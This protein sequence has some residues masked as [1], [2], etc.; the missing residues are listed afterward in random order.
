MVMIF[1]SEIGKNGPAWMEWRETA[2]T[3]LASCTEERYCQANWEKL[4]NSGMHAQIRFVDPAA[5]ATVLDITDHVG[6]AFQLCHFLRSERKRQPPLNVSLFPDTPFSI[7]DEYNIA[8]GLSLH[9]HA[10]VYKN[11]SIEPVLPCSKRGIPRF[12][13]FL[14]L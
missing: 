2:S 14:A 6:L 13:G 10:A 7:G 11:L 9:E 1:N 8:L 3:V 12:D 4:I 5:A